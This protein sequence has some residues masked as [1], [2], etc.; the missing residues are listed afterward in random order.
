MYKRRNVIKVTV[1]H[2]AVPS[3]M[4]IEKTEHL[5]E[6][7]DNTAA[8]VDRVI[9]EFDILEDFV[10][11][12]VTKNKKITIGL[13]EEVGNLKKNRYKDM[14]PF[15]DNIVTLSKPSGQPPTTYI[16]ASEVNHFNSTLLM[17]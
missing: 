2:G 13:N 6:D 12:H 5:T 8:E 14:V 15:D 1:D 17:S 7:L 11:V 10:D 4:F 9:T 3:H 16:N